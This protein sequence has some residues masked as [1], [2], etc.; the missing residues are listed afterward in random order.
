VR[1]EGPDK[2]RVAATVP[3]QASARTITRDPKP[4]RIYL[5]AATFE[6]APAGETKAEPKKGQWRSVVPGSFAILV[7]G[8]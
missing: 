5:S 1:E 2:F 3:T 6:P 8:E 4:Y 7:V